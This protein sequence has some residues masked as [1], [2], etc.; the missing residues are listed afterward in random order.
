MAKT[1]ADLIKEA[2]ALGLDV[3]TKAKVAEIQALIS[4]AQASQS[5]PSDKD[6][7]DGEIHLAKAGKRS[8]KAIA[9]EE[10]KTAKEERKHQTEDDSKPKVTVKPSR[11]RAERRGKLFRESL[12]KVDQKKS[13]NLDEA[14]KLAQQT[15]PVKFDA[16][17]EAH[18]NLAVDPRH[19]DQNVRDNIILPNGTGKTIRIA[20]VSD[21]ETAAKAAGANLFKVDE[22][23]ANLDK[24]NIDFDILIASPTLMPRLGKYARTLGPRG[25]MPNPKSGTVSN[26]IT[27]AVA[28]AKAGRVEYRVDST[29]IVH[30][31]VGKVSFDEAK[32]KENI[33]TVLTSIKSNKPSSV[34]GSYIKAIH[35]STTMGPSITVDL[36]V[37]A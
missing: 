18:I 32:L 31:G 6:A 17:V 8:A 5:E 37:I 10:A 3:D 11:S 12:A 20:V 34:K 28:E 14:I 24:G 13:Y 9:E 19:A 2:V 33:E 29:G 35:L 21:D 16:T 27:R 30:L 7:V 26:D 1:K 22:I 25:L 23:L 15:S 4:Q 36:S